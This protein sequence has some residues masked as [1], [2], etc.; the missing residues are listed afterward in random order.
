MDKTEELRRR[1]SNKE[2]NFTE[3]KPNGAKRDELRRTIVAFANSLPEGQT[4]VLYV[5][6]NDDGSPQ[7]VEDTDSMQKT[8]RR[9]CAGDCYPP[10]IPACAVLNLGEQ[11]VLAVEISASDKRPHFAG[12]AFIRVGSESIAASPEIYQDLLTSRCSHAGQLLKLKG[13]IVTVHAIR[14][15]LGNPK[16]VTND[17]FNRSHECRVKD[18]TPAV[19]YLLEL[20]SSRNLSEPINN[21][22]I[23]HDDERHRPML[24]VR[25][26]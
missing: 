8:I 16:P 17:I 21:V 1:F 14:K 3:R 20:G 12:P 11:T 7:G 10:I 22:Q 4:G 15:V 26:S 6:V 2:D 24:I 9:I 18:V 5:G 25:P 13:Q 19:V 23:S